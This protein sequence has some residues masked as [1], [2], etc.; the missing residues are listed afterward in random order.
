MI[1]RLFSNSTKLND[2]KAT[3]AERVAHNGTDLPH[4]ISAQPIK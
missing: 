1:Q 4:P 3:N 2:E